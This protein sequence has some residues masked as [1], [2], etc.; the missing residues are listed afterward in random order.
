MLWQTRYEY[1][2]TDTITKHAA[3]TRFDQRWNRLL[4][5]MT[6]FDGALNST[7]STRTVLMGPQL[8]FVLDLAEKWWILKTLQNSHTVK[9]RWKSTN[10]IITPWSE[11]GYTVTLQA[12]IFP[13][14]ILGGNCALSFNELNFSQLNIIAYI[15]GVF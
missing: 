2:A 6:Q 9:I 10:G 11:I 3:W 7:S 1:A 5:T 14:I 8:T 13:N 15:K 12:N 4:Q